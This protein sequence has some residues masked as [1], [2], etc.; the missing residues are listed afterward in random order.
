MVYKSSYIFWAKTFSTIIAPYFKILN[1][2]RKKYDP[3]LIKIKT[4]LVTEY[5]R[6][7]D[8]IIIAPILKSIKSNFPNAKII[9]ICSDSAKEIAEYLKLADKVIGVSVPWTNWRWS[10]LEWY[11]IR[12]FAK[13]FRL[14]GID[15]AIDFKGDIRNSWLL[16]NIHSKVSFGYN[17]TGGGYF[18]TNPLVMNQ[19][20][21]QYNRASKL[22]EEFGCRFSSDNES[23]YHSNKDGCIVLH[24]GASDFA[25]SWP[26]SHWMELARLLSKKFKV[27]IVI[28]NDSF[29]FFQKFKTEEIELQY[30]EGSLVSFC[31]YINNQKFLIALDSMAGHLASYFGIPVISLYGSQNPSLTKPKNKYGKIIKPKTICNHD[32]N[33]WRLCKLCIESISPKTVYEIALKHILFIESNL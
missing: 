11:K 27:S 6:I 29:G 7:G 12:N 9:L 14:L 10:F 28:T 20:I 8:V 26:A 3:K 23:R 5:H 25:R 17:T 24:P 4:I 19:S 16:W 33:H 21:H 30:F 32:R 13:S 15:L 31:N 22:I 1:L 2:F 18:Y